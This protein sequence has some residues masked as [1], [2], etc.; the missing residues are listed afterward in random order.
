[1]SKISKIVTNFLILFWMFII[2][3]PLFP[4][5][6]GS[7][8]TADEYYQTP[9]HHFPIDPT[10]ENYIDVFTSGDLFMSFLNTVFLI[11]ISVIVTTILAS[12]VA[13]IL[14]RFNFKFRKLI[15]G[16]FLII[17]FF[18]LAVM[19]VS[20][21]RVMTLTHLNNTFIGLALLYSVQDI[22]IIYLFRDNIR[23][24]SKNIDSSARILGASYFH[25]YWKLI[26]PN[27]RQTIII[28]SV[29]KTINIYNDFYFQ[30]LYLT[31]NKTISTFLYQFTAP[32][33]M[34]WPQ[35]CATI[36]TL[37]IFSISLLFLIVF[38]NK[39]FTRRDYD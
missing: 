14:E 22:V 2:L 27:L 39:K 12:M 35:I 37:L 21:F 3:F 20:I 24:L 38:I 36:I 11:I 25:I 18:P 23:K 13:Y 19:Q 17:S 33:E 32:Y 30:S 6:I 9:P 15:I 28:V 4:I 16:L 7:F 29:F 1:M 34:Q 10:F 5:L 26:L 8:K 31:Q